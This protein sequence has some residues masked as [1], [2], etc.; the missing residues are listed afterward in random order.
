MI[1]LG[2]TVTKL[3]FQWIK[4]FHFCLT[5]L[6]NQIN[7]SCYSRPYLRRLG[8]FLAT[9][10]LVIGNF[11][12]LFATIS[13]MGIMFIVYQWDELNWQNYWLQYIKLLQDSQRRLTFAVSSGGVI[14]VTTYMTAVIWNTS[15]NRWLATGIIL[16]GLI[17]VTTLVLLGWQVW[18]RK[19]LQSES[20]SEHFLN[21][22]SANSS[23][24]RLRAVHYFH[25]L[26]DNS[27]LNSTQQKQLQEY[28][29]LMLKIESEPIIRKA[30]EEN[31]LLFNSYQTL[32]KSNFSE[33][34]T[35]LKIPVKSELFTR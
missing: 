32:T 16:Q 31:L 14:A 24:Q 8:L 29:L 25:D 3:L 19:F 1:N 5:R 7:R 2:I 34:K 35:P 12:L 13:G 27:K 23:L 28:F 18:Q 33:A 20:E 11:P 22:L 26:I 4:K 9:L 15:D 6:Q 17:S 30:L 10:I 21:N